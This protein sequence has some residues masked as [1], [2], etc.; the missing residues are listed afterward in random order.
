MDT[1]TEI[2]TA[3]STTPLPPNSDSS[4]EKG[5]IPGENRGFYTADLTE[6]AKS[7]MRQIVT[8]IKT[9]RGRIIPV[10]SIVLTTGTF[11]GGRIFIGEYDAPC[12]RLGEAAAIGLTESLNRLGFTTGRLKTGTPPRILRHT[13]D[14]SRLEIQD[15][16]A[17][18]IPFSFD[19][20]KIDRPMV[21]CH[22]V[23][24]NEET[25]KIIRENIGR[26]PLYSGKIHGVGPR[27]CPS[28][29]DKVMRFPERERHQLFVEPEGLET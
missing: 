2:I 21:P 26:S 23:Y 1:A 4:A 19:N 14:F 7:G 29:E 10:R 18:V 12:G 13:V 15:G 28:I 8:G 6:A 22:M 17:D 16:D 20:E 9:Q 27:Y 3:A 24:T 11:L 5:S 25:H